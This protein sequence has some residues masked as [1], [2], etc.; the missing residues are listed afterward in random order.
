MY[1]SALFLSA[2]FGGINIALVQTV[3]QAKTKIEIGRIAQSITVQ[4]ES[5]DTAD[6]GSGILIAKND[7][8]Y[9]LLTA[10]HVVK[11]ATHSPENDFGYKIRTPDGKVYQS[12]ASVKADNNL[13]LAIVT[14]RSKRRSS[15]G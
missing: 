3:S 2:I 10:A 6:K 11:T 15:G 9:V 7:D 12:K 13:D 14:F 8:L 4:I 5:I 1:R